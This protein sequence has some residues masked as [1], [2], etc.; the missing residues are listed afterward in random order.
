MLLDGFR[1]S[2]AHYD[3]PEDGEA[4]PIALGAMLSGAMIAV[5]RS[6]EMVVLVRLDR[7]TW[8]A[9]CAAD[10]PSPRSSHGGCRTYG[11]TLRGVDQS[12][13]DAG[14][15]DD[16]ERCASERDENEASVSR[17]PDA[18]PITERVT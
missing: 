5:G 4:A 6:S 1:Q 17:S 10:E 8:E 15:G 12:R 7:E 3:G 13:L 18:A 14:S 11:L 16:C 9:I 2:L